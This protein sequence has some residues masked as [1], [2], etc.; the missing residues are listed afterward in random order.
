MLCAI[1]QPNFFPWLGYF[2][3]IVRS[4]VFVFLDGVD[5]EKSGHSMQCY[6]NRVSLLGKRGEKI[7]VYCPVKREHGP[8]II[9]TVKIKTD[10]LW[11]DDIWRILNDNYEKAPYKEET[12]TLVKKILEYDTE[13]IS[14]FNINAIIEICKA[15][16]ISTDFHFQKEVNSDKHSTELLV[17]IIKEMGCDSYL[18]GKGGSK[19]Q[20]EEFFLKANIKTIPQ[21]FSQW[22]YAQGN[23]NNF[24]PGLSILDSLYWVG[25]S[26]TSGSLLNYTKHT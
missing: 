26:Q 24:I 11:K 15:L 16:N 19:Y 10:I 12:D 17:D 6:T 23:N 4:D 20:E 18:Y 7:N 22:E 13:Y 25:I 1:H 2:E 21:N 5:Y 9:N 8:Q 3:K 14:Q